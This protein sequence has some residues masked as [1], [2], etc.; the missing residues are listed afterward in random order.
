MKFLPR[1]KAEAIVYSIWALIDFL[2]FETYE[3]TPNKMY[4]KQNQTSLIC[5]EK[6]AKPQ[7]PTFSI[8]I[9]PYNVISEN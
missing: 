7:K 5:I 9:F 3:N 8:G 2:C 1:R 6:Y 4:E